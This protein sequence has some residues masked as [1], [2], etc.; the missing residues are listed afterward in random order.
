MTDDA[1]RGSCLC[2]GIRYQVHGPLRDVVNCHCTKCRKAHGAAF[3]TRATVQTSDFLLV[4]GESLLTRFSSSPGE[5]R[6]FCGRCGSSLFTRFDRRTD[7]LGLALGTLDSD[8]GVG[9]RVHLFVGSK[10][11]WH[12]IADELP[13]YQGFPDHSKG[14][15]FVRCSY[16]RSLGPFSTAPVV[17]VG[18]A[19]RSKGEPRG[20][21]DHCR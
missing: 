21:Q 18:D 3:R 4:A 1:L 8:P 9:P 7:V 16:P 6:M 2:G 15:I 12:E 17:Y 13:Q 19:R 14:P 5:H 20:P 10:A 11:P